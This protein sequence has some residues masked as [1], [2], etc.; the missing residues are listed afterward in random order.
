MASRL[1]LA[2]SVALMSALGR[3]WVWGVLKGSI[4]FS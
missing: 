4:F 2:A 3:V 1:L